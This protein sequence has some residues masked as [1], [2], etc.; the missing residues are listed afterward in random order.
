[1]GEVFRE[2][3]GRLLAALARRFGDLD[4]AEEVTSE[5]IETALIRWPTDGVPPNPGGWLMTTARRKAVDRL[6]RDQVY[7]AKLA[8]LQVESDRP[9]PQAAGDEL[10]DERL[11]LFFT[12]AHPAL[13][14]ED[15]GAL[16]LRCLA[17]LT[18]PEVARAFLV[19]TATMAKRIVRAKKRL[20]EARIPFRV[21]G[22]DELPDR[23]PGVLQVIYS[24]FTEG[25][26]ASSGPYLQ[27]LDLAEEAIRL[28]RIL[29]RLLPDA[30]EATGLLALMLLIHA[31]GDARTGPDGEIVLLEDQD[32]SRWDHVMI[33]E[34]RALVVAALTGGPSGPYAVQ[35]AIN[36]VH[37]EAPRFASTDWPQIVQLY[38]VLLELDPSPVI[39]LNRA[40]AIAFRDGPEA[41][42]AL[43]DE[44]ATEPR[45]QD[46]HPY[47]V[48]R[49]DL[50]R[51][52]GRLP[53]AITAYECALTL[54]GS[55]PERV[56]D[57]DQLAEM[58]QTADMETVYEA[59]GGAEGMLRLAAAWHELVMA[60]P[61]VSHAFHGGAKP[62]HTERLAAYWGEALGGPSAYT[63]T[64]GTEAEVQRLHAGNGE[65][66]EMNRRAIDCFDQAMTNADLT[67]PRVRGVLHDYFAWATFNTMYRHRTDDIDD[68]PIPQWSWDGRQ[69][70]AES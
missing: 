32:R 3:R 56:H 44:L 14:P 58:R 61:V 66:D 52:L 47:A 18:T 33:A 2:E 22:P 35:A 38:D 28:A 48:A 4:L 12:C 42:L 46:Y 15:R 21:P 70:A 64:Y 43:L 20:R 26:A 62:D 5:A 17:G 51:R 39:A 27:R 69:D 24:V 23:L 16:T 19:P 11:Q 54:A 31:R 34:G 53:E 25:Y 59:A 9:V 65:H 68:G 50:L 57:R 13:A 10:P 63:S 41:G 55:E 45:L 67:D 30:R 8:I 37:D 40:A 6:R 60:D 49:G 29:H 36:A 1:M 7:A